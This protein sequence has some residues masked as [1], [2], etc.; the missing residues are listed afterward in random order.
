SRQVR[1]L[2]A[3]FGFA[4][5]ALDAA[6]L[7]VAHNRLLVPDRIGEGSGG[8][9]DHDG[10]GGELGDVGGQ[11]ER[12]EHFVEAEPS[13]GRVGAFEGVD[14]A[15]CG[16]EDAAGDDEDGGG[17]SGS[18]RQLREDAQG[19]PSQ[20]D[21][22]AGVEPAGR[23][24]PQGAEGDAGGRADPD[25][26]EDGDAGGAFEGHVG[27][28]R[29]GAGDDEVDVGVIASFEPGGGGRAE[30]GAGVQG[31]DAEQRRRGGDVDGGRESGRGG[32]SG[33]DQDETG[34]ERGGERG[35]VQPAAQERFGRR[36][37][38]GR[39]WGLGQGGVHALTIR[40]VVTDR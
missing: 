40:P 26:G 17:G 12:M 31:R 1:E 22:E 4:D 15:A 8:A 33:G 36:G 7:S 28:G 25:G 18:G 37:G 38:G 27:H 34:Q 14:E 35:Q 21:V 23:A 32:R 5:G 9:L 11:G 6:G 20:D 3:R 19:D 16:V 39:G 24:E 10:H 13:G 30:I 2:A 29:V